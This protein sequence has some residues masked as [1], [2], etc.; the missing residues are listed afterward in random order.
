MNAEEYERKGYTIKIEYDED[1]QNPREDFD[2]AGVMVCFHRRYNLGDKHE[3][4]SSDFSGWSEL[5]AAIMR[6]HNA[7]VILP[8]YLY[9]HSGI[10]MYTTGNTTYHQHAAWDSGQV[11]F[12]YLSRETIKEEWGY[13]RITKKARE[14]LENYLRGEVETYDQFLRGE[15]YG[16]MIESP[17]G[18]SL[19]SCW[20]FY[21][22]DYC[23]QEAESMVDWYVKEDEK[24]A[25]LDLR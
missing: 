3:Y 4:D 7:P 19:D 21:G 20:G 5:E 22:I 1:A 11:G 13:T 10:T 2:N 16:Y 8:L 17:D 25:A 14:F 23:K 15:V 6:D 12:I 18:D 9:D 24:T